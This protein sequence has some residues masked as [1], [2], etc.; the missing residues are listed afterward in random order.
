V[1]VARKFVIFVTKKRYVN[2]DKRGNTMQLK[3]AQMRGDMVKEITAPLT[4]AGKTFFLKEDIPLIYRHIETTPSGEDV[5]VFYR[6]LWYEAYSIDFEP[7]DNLNRKAAPYTT[8][9]RGNKNH[10]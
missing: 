2:I 4:R 3:Y 7:C 9:I 1:T 6:G 5:E 10:D 8:F